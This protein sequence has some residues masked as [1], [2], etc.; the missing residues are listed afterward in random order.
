M[1]V[2]TSAWVSDLSHLLAE[3]EGAGDVPTEV[4]PALLAQVTDQVTRLDTLRLILAA[5][6]V[7]GR[8]VSVAPPSKP[9]CDVTQE[10][11]AKQT[12]VPLRTIRW[13]TR[14][15]RVP[16]YKRGRNRMVRVSDIRAR[17]ESARGQGVALTKLPDVAS[18][19]DVR[20]SQGGAP[21]A[22]AHA[23]RVR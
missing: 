13:L 16:A 6:L 4:L 2:A 15:G 9:E 8:R 5:R 11:A 14:T 18:R 12:G 21:E 10:E 19:H 22:R 17:I 20:G 7:L 23:G 1:T 3:P